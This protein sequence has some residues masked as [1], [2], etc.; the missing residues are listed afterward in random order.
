MSVQPRL[1]F[2]VRRMRSGDVSAVLAIEQAAYDY[3]WTERI[4]RDCLRVGYRCCVAT[5]LED[6][7]VGYSLLS[8]AMAE[9]HILNLCVATQLRGH[10]IAGLLLDSIFAQAEA[11]R[12]EVVLL[13][14]RPSN[15]AARRLY[16]RRGFEQIATRPGY[17]PAH[18]GR[19]DALLLSHQL[20][21]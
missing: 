16:K 19:E 1:L 12:A 5:D 17:Y 4:F 13:E 11:E 8:V 21:S 14:V 20:I 3:P 7:V 15:R 18:D 6:R 2:R 9:A 10:G